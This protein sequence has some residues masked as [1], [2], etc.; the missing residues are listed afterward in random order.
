MFEFKITCHWDKPTYEPGSVAGV[1]L[2]VQNLGK[3]AVHLPSATLTLAFGTYTLNSKNEV[4]EPGETKEVAAI[5]AQL[6]SDRSGAFEYNV[7]MTITYYAS[8]QWR[9]AETRTWAKAG[10]VQMRPAEILPVFV[11]RSVRTEDRQVGD[12]LAGIIRDWGLETRTVG[13]EISAPDEQVP[14]RVRQEILAAPGLVLIAT[15]RSLDLITNVWKTFEWAHAELG[16]AFAQDLPILV[17]CDETVEP[18]GLPSYLRTLGRAKW[19]RFS[20]TNPSAVRQEINAQMQWFRQSIKQIQAKRKSD[21]FWGGVKDVL[22]VAG[23]LAAVV[24]AGNA[25]SGDDDK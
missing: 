5:S 17:M 18:A 3:V 21:K 14:D 11:S 1:K 25:L 13:V 9:P 2:T 24:V 10:I 6:P 7:G 19:I 12:S 8:G 22:A 16:M 4:V 23:A 20:S 15:R